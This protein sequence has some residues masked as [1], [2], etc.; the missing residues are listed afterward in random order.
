[1]TATLQNR[2]SKHGIPAVFCSDFCLMS[3]PVTIPSPMP[4]RGAP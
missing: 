4:V 2:L 1:M 3:M